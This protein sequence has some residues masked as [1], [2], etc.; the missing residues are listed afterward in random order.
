MYLKDFEE[1]RTQFKK[2]YISLERNLSKSDSV[3]WMFIPT[4]K[5]LKQYFINLSKDQTFTFTNK[6]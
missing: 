5:S 4:R 2:F 3:S 1:S 6:A